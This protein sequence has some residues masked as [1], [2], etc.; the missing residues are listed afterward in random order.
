MSRSNEAADYAHERSLTAVQSKPSNE[1]PTDADFKSFIL[2]VN[3]H[4]QRSSV[5]TKALEALSSNPEMKKCTLIQDVD[6][7]S[8]RPV[9]LETVP[10]LVLKSERRALKDEACI[11][12]IHEYVCKGAVPYSSG[13]QKKT[14]GH[15]NKKESMWTFS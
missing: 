14:V 6:A 7:L 9:W 8:S 13:K 10:C 12:F 3:S 15:S 1:P 5:C 11:Q 4:S 2:Y